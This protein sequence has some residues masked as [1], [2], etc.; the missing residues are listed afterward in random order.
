M[1]NY[2]WQCHIIILYYECR[3]ASACSIVYLSVLRF[4]PAQT[5]IGHLESIQLGPSQY[6]GSSPSGCSSNHRGVMRLWPSH[7][8]LL[9]WHCHSLLFTSQIRGHTSCLETRTYRI[10]SLCNRELKLHK[11]Y[12]RK[13]FPVTTEELEAG[14]QPVTSL[15][16]LN[17]LQD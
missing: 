10:A 13:N 6:G 12:C 3:P 14:I 15:E 9:Y 8:E 4:F 7:W 1:W 2:T 11:Q 17:I 5:M 16:A